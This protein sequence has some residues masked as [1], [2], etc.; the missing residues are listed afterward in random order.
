MNKIAETLS[1][2]FGS[3]PFILFHAIMYAVWIT[4]HVM[5]EFDENFEMLLTSASLEAIFLALFI[6]RAENVAAE[7]MEEQN[8]KIIKEVK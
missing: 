3:A 4:V 6:L 8:K 1:N 5:M 2:W 7:R